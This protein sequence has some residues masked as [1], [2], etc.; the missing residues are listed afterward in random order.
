VVSAPSA[1][2]TPNGPTTFCA[3]G[4]VV[5]SAP[6]GYDYEWSANAGNATTRTVTVTQSGTYSVTVSAGASC[7]ATSSATVTVN[8][9]PTV[10]ISASGPTTFCTGGSVTLT[11][12]SGTGYLWSNGSTSSSISATQAGTYEVTVTSANGCSNSASQVVNIVSTPSATITPSGSTSICPGSS[13]TLSAPSGYT[14]SWSN[15]ANTES[16][17]VQLA[18]TYSVTV[19]AGASCTATSSVTITALTA[20][21]ATVTPAGPVTICAGETV[22][23]SAVGG[24]LYEWSNGATTQTISPTLAGS[25]TVTVT[26]ANNC[27]A[28]SAPITV[29]AANPPATPTVTFANDVLSS[30]SAAGYQWYR[31]GAIIN[32]ADGQQYTPTQN[33]SYTVVITDASGCSSQSAAVPVVISSIADVVNKLTVSV[34]PNPST[35]VFYLSAA[36]LSGTSNIV[37][38]DMAGREVFNQTVEGQLQQYPLDLSSTADGVYILRL[39]NG[40]AVNNTRLI[41]Y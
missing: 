38:L 21:D 16:I 4:N 23:L 27:E 29:T 11:A 10:T 9:L 36:N 33:G 3:G 40:D 30:S 12:S 20:P 19:S 5:L 14:Y 7:T 1:T 39:S 34:Q 2:I 18:G 35:G 6:A 26:N 17:T 41:V 8:S 24:L 32:G 31:D 13:V 15:S 25:Y 22:T 37:I 28:V